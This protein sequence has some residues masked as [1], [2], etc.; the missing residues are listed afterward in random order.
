MSK[1]IVYGPSRLEGTVSISGAKNAALP[2]LVSCLLSSGWNKI[3]HVPQLKDIETTLM[4]LTHLGVQVH[5]VHDCV[6]INSD[7]TSCYRAPYELVKTMR[8][9]IL[10]LGPLLARFGKAEVSLPGGCAIGE[11]PINLHLAGL[12]K[13]G[14]TI[15][16]ENGYV[17]AEAKQLQGTS[18]CFDIPTVTG[19]ENLMMAATLAKG[20][21]V[22]E[23][24]AKEP[25]IVD[26]ANYLNAMGARIVGAGMDKVV[27]EGVSSLEASSY[28]IMADRIEAG[29]VLIAVCAAGGKVDIKNCNPS[30]LDVL[31][32]KLKSA[33]MKIESETDSIHVESDQQVGVLK[34][35]TKPYPGFPTDLQAQMMVMLTQA[36]GTSIIT[37]NIFENRFN[38][39]GEFRRMGA[40]ITID[41]R[42]AVIEGGKKLNGAPV[43]ATD[44]RASASLVIAGLIA[45]G[46]TEISRLYH[47]DRGYENLHEKLFKLGARIER[48]YGE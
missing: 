27:I 2:I 34:I 13:L 5:R 17:I 4:L 22:L 9:S 18:I 15:R 20:T 41:G 47:L 48:L 16:L 12:E 1:M 46:K 36:A 21:T 37:E 11:R 24:A 3:S 43:M 29:T 28:S 30:H 14:A 19:T 39:V 31:I 38:H 40:N 10:V 45:E 7:T 35:Q 26:L 32:D 33:G 44:L 25:E 8:A 42:S 6:Q 23:N